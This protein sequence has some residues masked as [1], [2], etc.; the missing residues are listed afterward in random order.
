MKSKV[1]IVLSVLSWI[2]SSGTY[3]STIEKSLEELKKVA[4]S[5]E[6]PKERVQMCMR[7]LDRG[8]YG[9]LSWLNRAFCYGEN[10]ET[11]EEIINTANKY[12]GKLKARL[13]LCHNER[14]IDQIARINFTEMVFWNSEKLDYSSYLDYVKHNFTNIIRFL[15]LNKSIKKW[16]FLAITSVE[17]LL[18]Y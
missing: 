2:L 7:V 10:E 13:I 3:A 5:S 17:K 12:D 8:W 15:R 9:D 11:R 4:C 18:I 14:F 6:N 16:I 1:Y